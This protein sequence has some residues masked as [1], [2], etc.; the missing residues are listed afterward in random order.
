LE[1]VTRFL[2]ILLFITPAMA[3]TDEFT[4]NVNKSFND[5]RQRYVELADTSE[6]WRTRAE[7][8]EARKVQVVRITPVAG[9]PVR[10]ACP[11]LTGR[12]KCKPGRT[13]S[14]KHN[15]KC[16]VWTE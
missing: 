13:Q 1:I 16:G 12:Q 6:Y 9:N 2:A 15:C 5:L 4:D 7:T 3:C 8:L 14:V 11:V 10:N